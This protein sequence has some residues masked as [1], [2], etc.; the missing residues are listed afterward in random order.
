[1]ELFQRSTL[2]HPDR[3][4]HME[5]DKVFYDKLAGTMRA[6]GNVVCMDGKN[7]AVLMGDECEY[8]EN[9]ATATDSS[10]VT[11]HALV[12]DY[13]SGKDTLFVHADTLKLF[14]YHVRTDTMSRVLK[15]YHHVRA[16]RTDIQAVGDSLL[17]D[18]KMQRISLYRD[19]IVW[20]DNRQILGE[21]IHVF[22][23]D[24]TVDSVYVRDQAL[25]VERLDSLHFNQ[26]S[27]KLLRAYF[28]PEGEIESGAADG[29]VCTIIYP[30]EKD[31]TILY[32]NYLEAAKM[33]MQMEDRKLKRFVGFPSPVGVCY[34]VGGAPPEHAELPTFAWFD[35]IRPRDQFDLFEWRPKKS[36]KLL[37]TKPRRE[38]P[39]QYVSGDKTAG[40]VSQD[41]EDDV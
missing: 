7:R 40:K 14:S 39:L 8:L 11:G 18:N 2:N 1:M 3:Q 37:R 28:S 22:A 6:A 21:E 4:L 29:N 12:K 16:Y 9:K 5:A 36:D 19:P 32:Q 15:G 17:Y 24:S 41:K 34:P 10:Y 25:M 23:N 27:A 33:R 38:S 30:L 20:A 26:L 31:S 35:Y 13:S